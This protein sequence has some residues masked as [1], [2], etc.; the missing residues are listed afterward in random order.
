MNLLPVVRHISPPRLAEERQRLARFCRI[1][2]NQSGDR[3][4]WERCLLR[5]QT[6]R[7]W[8]GGW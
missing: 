5:R 6:G 1:K 7:P 4:Q 3:H 2:C 8:T